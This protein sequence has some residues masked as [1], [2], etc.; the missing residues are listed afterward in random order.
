MTIGDGEYPQV[1]W[2]IA[3]RD[4]NG[5]PVPGVRLRVEDLDGHE[6]FLYPV[7][8]YLPDHIPMSDE[9]GR[10]VFHHV[11]NNVEFSEKT[12]QVFFVPIVVHRTPRYICRFL[13]GD[14]ELARMPFGELIKW[15]ELKSEAMVKRQWKT[16]IW[17]TNE[18]YET[19]DES[20]SQWDSR[21]QDC[22]DFDK[23]GQ[24]TPE[25]S[26]AACYARWWTMEEAAIEWLGNRKRIETEKTF[27][28]LHHEI[29]V[30]VSDK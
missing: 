9:A 8:D 13:C 27:A 12:C 29:T 6:F 16:P 25:M 30:P 17:P 22:Y 26:A 14:T 23:T 15:N 3:F 19:L 1:E 28:V 2:Q 4:S 10:M 11:T 20:F 7:T 21:V 18:L 24:F 5:L